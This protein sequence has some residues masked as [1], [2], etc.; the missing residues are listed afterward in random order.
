MRFGMH[1]AA[2]GESKDK[3][4]KGSFERQKNADQLKLADEQAHKDLERNRMIGSLMQE[5]REYEKATMSNVL[6]DRME[7]II[8]SSLA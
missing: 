6:I 4:L 7:K 1:S 2:L 5:M 3:D 8:A